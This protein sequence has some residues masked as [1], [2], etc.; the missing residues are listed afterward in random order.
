L[1]PLLDFLSLAIFYHWLSA[2]CSS[3]LLFNN[4]IPTPSDFRPLDLSC[5]D[6]IPPIANYGYKGAQQTELDT[7]PNIHIQKK[8]NRD[9]L[10]AYLTNYPN[11]L[12]Q[13]ISNSSQ[14]VSPL[15]QGVSRLYQGVSPLYQGVSPLSKRLPDLAWLPGLHQTRSPSKPCSWKKWASPKTFPG[16][17]TR[18]TDFSQ[19]SSKRTTFATL[20][21]FGLTP[22]SLEFFNLCITYVRI[23]NYLC[24]TYV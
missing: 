6:L 10:L 9:L 24:M 23:G 1:L 21:L 15:Y 16:Q 7:N 22:K 12:N 14:G 3:T 5:H 19:K 2:A 11:R 17:R 8:S 18:F 4:P 20:I 13:R